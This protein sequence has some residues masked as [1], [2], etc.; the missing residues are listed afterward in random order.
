MAKIPSDSV[1]QLGIIIPAYNEAATIAR[2]VRDSMKISKSVC[3]INDGSTDETAQLALEAGAT[4]INNP[5]KCGQG[6]SLL[7]GITYLARHGCKH[8]A[9]VDGDG[10][11][12]VGDLPKMLS[13]HATQSAQL[14]LGSRLLHWDARTFPSSKAAANQLASS[15]L[16]LLFGTEVSDPACGI[17]IYDTIFTEF[18]QA[19]ADFSFAFDTLLW[20]HERKLKIAEA[21]V[22][23]RYDAREAF[24]TSKQEILD[25]LNLCS[26]RLGR[27]NEA[28]DSVDFV[29]AAVESDKRFLLICS[30]YEFALLPIPTHHAYLVQQQHRWF[31]RARPNGTGRFLVEFF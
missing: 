21:A 4:V 8:V 25:F 1:D 13:I 9:S 15:M 11:H 23:V 28:C 5:G 24:F 14:T 16:N 29:Q 30:G 27:A 17:R 12:C 3:V 26:R 6:A 20:A 31:M 2:V 10:A 7:S 19:S 18:K 22:R